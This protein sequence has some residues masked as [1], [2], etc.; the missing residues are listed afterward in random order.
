M[1]GKKTEIDLSEFGNARRNAQFACSVVKAK[2]TDEQLK[3][4]LAVLDDDHYGIAGILRVINGWGVTI[5]R[6]QL[7]KHRAKSCLCFVKR[8]ND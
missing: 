2:M 6:D 5:G 4:L 1:S 3:K 7:A 8:D